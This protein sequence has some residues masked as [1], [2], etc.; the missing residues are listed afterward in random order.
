MAKIKLQKNKVKVSK[1]KIVKKNVKQKIAKKSLAKKMQVKKAIVKKSVKVKGKTTN[2]AKKIVIKKPSSKKI[3]EKKIENKIEDIKKT[4]VALIKET[5]IKKKDR[6]KKFDI[7]KKKIKQ[8]SDKTEKQAN[9]KKNLS[10]KITK[11]PVDNF[12]NSGEEKVSEIKE[13]IV[14][15]EELN[16]KYQEIQKEYDFFEPVSLDNKESSTNEI[17]QNI[18]SIEVKNFFYKFQKFLFKASRNPIR[19][20]QCC[21][22]DNSTV[23]SHHIIKNTGKIKLNFL[24]RG[25]STE[26]K[27]GFWRILI[28]PAYILWKGIENFF[29]DVSNLCYGRLPSFFRFSLPNFWKKSLVGFII[30]CFILI[31]PFEAVFIY[32]AGKYEKGKVLGQVISA[33]EELKAGGEYAIGNNLI[34]AGK[35]F[36]RSFENFKSAQR[37]LDDSNSMLV[38]VLKNIPADGGAVL[39]GDN[40]LS[41]GENIS[42]AA[43]R[44]NG[45]IG[46]ILENQDT[47]FNKDSIAINDKNVL[48]FSFREGFLEEAGGFLENIILA[49][50]DLEIAEK[51]LDRIKLNLLDDEQKQILFL[52][53]EKLPNIISIIGDFYELLDTS[54]EILGKDSLKRYLFVFQNNYEL[55]ATGGFIGSFAVIDIDQ[56]KIKKIDIPEGGSYAVRGGL[57]DRIS[58]PIPLYLISPLWQFHDANWWPDFPTS[59]RKLMEFYEISGGS[60]VDG[61]IAITPEIIINLLKITGPIEMEYYGKIVDADN[62]MWTAQYQVE[63]EYDKNKNNPKKFIADF[64]EKLVSRLSSQLEDGSISIMDVFTILDRQIKSKGLQV[65]FADQKAQ[66]IAEKY[67]LSGAVKQPLGD[68]LM[69]VNSNI[70]GGKTDGV[71]SQSVKLNTTIRDD[72]TTVNSLMIKRAHY[73]DQE[74]YFQ[75][76]RNVDWIRIYVPKGAKLISASGFKNPDSNFFQEPEA[77]LNIDKD[78]AELDSGFK[79]DE[80]SGIRIYSQFGKTVFAGW[81]MVDAGETAAIEL[82]YELPFK[83]KQ[84]AVSDD[85]GNPISIINSIIDKFS[86]DS[87]LTAENNFCSYSLL[88]Q[89]QAGITSQFRHFLNTPQNWQSVWKNTEQF[90]GVL[91]KDKIYGEIFK[92]E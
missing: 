77:K 64:T 76:I 46:M 9:D 17:K 67:S 32:K 71:I 66:N 11:R 73:G 38:K 47:I 86:S 48:I 85:E 45:S 36:N 78:L 31:L 90:S 87:D 82:E 24:K 6:K 80:F 43:C 34:E 68:Y 19:G 14:I 88:M 84:S 20:Q 55:R 89:K 3:A 72:G 91:D 50:K 62:F 49:K 25:I 60:T 42:K 15:S 8:A 61:V 7:K 28:F 40:L 13:K 21:S 75:R 79:I 92:I 54:V 65:Y 18:K 37:T 41:F 56:G 59:A 81:S 53:K 5:L 44:L 74:D 12:L 2:A 39:S 83:V 63:L 29:I 4:K 52:I 69:V 70:A 1:A 35:H 33:A 26:K 51:N 22:G 23:I 16:V 27:L 57:T 10:V 30:V 58:A